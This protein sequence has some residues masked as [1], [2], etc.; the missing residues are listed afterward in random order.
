MEPPPSSAFALPP[1]PSRLRRILRGLGIA[2]VALFVAWHLLFQVVRTALDLW[3][4]PVRGWCEEN[5]THPFD[6]AVFNKLDTSTQRYGSLT[7][8][9]T[10]WS[11]YA[12]PVARSASFL[13]VRLEF[14]DGTWVDLNSFNE[15]ADTHHFFR[16]GGWRQRKLEDSLLGI[17]NTEVR[18]HVDR[19]VYEAYVR[20]RLKAW[21]DANPND[22]R[23]VLHIRL[24]MRDLDLPHPD[25]PDDPPAV[26]FYRLGDFAPDGSAL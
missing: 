14:D 25:R 16:V 11:M 9:V 20:W 21:R 17:R 15:P 7:G 3:S 1:P 19:P 26:H 23:T 5:I 18:N 13:T 24:L 4:S 10:G 22:P 6:R 12:P 8:I 2:A